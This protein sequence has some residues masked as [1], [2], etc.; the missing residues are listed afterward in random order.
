M[1]RRF[2]TQSD[3]GRDMEV[4]MAATVFRD[5]QA[6]G[7]IP[8]GTRLADRPPRD[9]VGV[10]GTSY[11]ARL[12]ELI[13]DRDSNGRLDL[14][15]DR[16]RSAGILEGS[17]TTDTVERTISGDARDRL[18]D[19]FV[20]RQDRRSGISDYGIQPNR[21]GRRIQTYSQGMVVQGSQDR[22]QSAFL[23]D[24]GTRAARSPDEARTLAR[25]AVAGAQV[26][27]GRGDQAH[28]QALLADTGAALMGAGRREAAA[29]VYRE[30][31]RSPYAEAPVN[32]M[33]REMD[34]VQRADGDYT[35]GDDIRLTRRGTSNSVDVSDFRSTYGELAQQRLRQIE[36]HDRMEARLGRTVD[37]SNM[38][39][40][41]AYFQSYAQGH[42]TDDVRQEYQRYLESSFVHTG[43]GVEW[44]DRVAEDDRPAHMTE[45]L[46]SQP[47]DDAGRALVDCEGYTYMTEAILGGITD[48][49]SGQRRFDVL[50][51]S[52]PGHIVAGVFDRVGGQG[53]TV[54]NDDTELLSQQVVSGQARVQA[55]GEEI[56][57]NTY[58]VIGFGRTPS[59]ASATQTEDGAPALG[60]AVWDGR[61]VVGTVTPELQSGFREWSSQTLGGSISQYI[62]HLDRTRAPN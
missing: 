17:P 30:L 10:E 49:E 35:P 11:E 54:N 62:G 52:R 41:Q 21:R 29:G 5:L 20:G 44:T 55:L 24:A 57:G 37:P 8:E 23:A 50:Y 47:R 36:T 42:S 26:L 32:L 59:A 15:V 16:L 53:F 18:S 13:T 39:D 6:A 31:S 4:A 22:A 33:Q 9:G 19:A 51:A 28:A 25:E 3:G 2:D 27:N 38:A 34:A 58:D 1:G 61:S 14:D 40:A 43:R 45:L 60:A 48:D 56:A 12:V 46:A 7:Y